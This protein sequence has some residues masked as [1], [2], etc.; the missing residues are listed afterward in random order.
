[1]AKNIAQK[2]TAGT[3]STQPKLARVFPYILIV[4]GTVGLICSFIIM[5]DKIALLT[6][7][8]FRPT[9]DLNPVIS[10]GSVMASKQGSA[11]GFPN[12]LIGLAA[13]AAILTVGVSML[14]GAKFARWFWLTFAAGVALGLGFAYWLLFESV[15]RIRALCPY[16]LAVDVVLITTF[17]YL[18]LYIIREGHLP[19]PG[20]LMGLVDFARRHHAEMLIIW[21]LMLTALILQHFWYYYGQFI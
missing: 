20:R 4:A 2:T 18:C 15:Y 3:G 1:M 19:V 9:C 5:L 11:F 8:S 12:P 7:P 16:C 17:W 14:A 13:F 21:L 10:C 6:N